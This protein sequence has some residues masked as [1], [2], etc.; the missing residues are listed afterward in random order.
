MIGF[1]LSV[2]ASNIYEDAV[3]DVVTP[4]SMVSDPV[5]LKVR[6]F[7]L[8][9]CLIVNYVGRISLFLQRLP[10]HSPFQHLSA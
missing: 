5:V 2:M 3:I 9:N 4:E 8:I 1:D 6:A 10:T 7:A